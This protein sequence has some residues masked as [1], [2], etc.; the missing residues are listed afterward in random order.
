L[1]KI[2]HDNHISLQEL[3]RINP[4][5]SNPNF[6]Y[7][8][9]VVNL[10]TKSTTNGYTWNPSLIQEPSTPPPVTTYGVTPTPMTA[11]ENNTENFPNNASSQ[12]RYQ[13]YIVQPDATSHASLAPQNV[14][15]EASNSDIPNIKDLSEG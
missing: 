3:E 4:Q 15:S 13:P 12:L 1:T 8:G 2:A 6:I 10:P 11:N 5:I 7:S 14:P 9:D